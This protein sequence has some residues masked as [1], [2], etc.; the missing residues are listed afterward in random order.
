MLCAFNGGDRAVVPLVPPDQARAY[1]EAEAR[2]IA[3]ERLWDFLAAKVR[4]A[5]PFSF[6][7]AGDGEGRFIAA[8]AASLVPGLAAADR[9]AMLGEIWFNWFGEPA[10]RVDAGDLAV[11]AAQVDAAFRGA[12]LVGLTSAAVLEYDRQHAGY[13]SALELWFEDI[14]APPGQNCTD[15]SYHVFLNDRDPFLADMLS[16]ARFVG[17]IS[18]HAGGVGAGGR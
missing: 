11:L 2:W 17:V 14:G 16:P 5:E 12:D 1:R 3:A 10:E 9:E 6:V 8:T 4:A 13:R 7:R 15:A 18:P